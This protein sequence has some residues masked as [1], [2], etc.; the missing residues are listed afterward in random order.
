MRNNGVRAAVGT[1][2]DE[3]RE[4]DEGTE[5]DDARDGDTDDDEDGD[6]YEEEDEEVARDTDAEAGA[7]S[8]RDGRGGENG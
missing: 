5:R 7:M 1:S 2:D 3:A 8:R 4:G 6:A